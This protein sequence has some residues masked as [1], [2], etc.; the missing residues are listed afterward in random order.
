DVPLKLATWCGLLLAPAGLACLLWQLAAWLV[1]GTGAGWLVATA[2]VLL[3]GGLQLLCLGIL[4]RYV[5]AI[6][7]DTKGRPNFVVK[8][9]YGLESTLALRGRTSSGSVTEK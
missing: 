2:F 5:S 1:A 3:V 7:Q 8:D 9:V 4:G 6:F